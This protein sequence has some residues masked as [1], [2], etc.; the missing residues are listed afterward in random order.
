MVYLGAASSSAWQSPLL[1]PGKRSNMYAAVLAERGEK[2]SRRASCKIFTDQF[3]RLL[4]FLLRAAH[5][6][7]AP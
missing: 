5:G 3:D 7:R 4:S 6:D 1:L 2:K